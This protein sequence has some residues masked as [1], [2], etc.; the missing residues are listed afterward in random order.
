MDE[1]RLKNYR[2]FKSEQRARI[3]PLTI[4]VG[5]NSAG[6]S[7]FLA[8]IRALWNLYHNHRVPNFNEEPFD[9]GTFDNIVFSGYEDKKFSKTFSAGFR[10]DDGTQI[11]DGHLPIWFD[12]EFGRRGTAPFPI[13]LDMKS[14]E[15]N[16]KLTLNSRDG[17]LAQV[18]IQTKRGSW[19]SE[20]LQDSIKLF[21]ENRLTNLRLIMPELTPISLL[22]S[23]EISTT[24][25]GDI[26]G[27]NG[28]DYTPVSK[29]SS[30]QISDNDWH[31]VVKLLDVIYMSTS[32][33][34]LRKR[35]S[36]ASSP[37]RSKPI[38]IYQS[39][40]F[41]WDPEGDFAPMYLANLC[42]TGGNEWIKIRDKLKE[43]GSQSGLFDE[44]SIHSYE[45]HGGGPFQVEVRRSGGQPKG[46]N[47][48]L[49]DMGY[50]V[51]QI[52][53]VATE[54]LR[55]D[56]TPLLLLQQPEVHLHPSAQAALGTL[57]LQTADREQIVIVESHSDHLLNRIRMDLRDRVGD[58]RPEDVS[59]LY[60]E[61]SDAGSMIYS[62]RIDEQGNMIDAPESYGRFFMDETKRSLN[63]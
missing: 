39:K 29:K 16:L 42:E 20:D 61:D 41:A 54:L 44:I 27:K 46:K 1:I 47:R 59:I 10:I 58:S 52:L 5:E 2:C 17:N 14:K 60:F 25:A 24:A 11:S 38:R 28:V 35:P 3:A 18:F 31:Q 62:L 13:K 57:L 19:K 6:K 21:E 12:V 26:W 53:P 49:I 37:V 40:L 56:P 9:F 22:Q 7:S 51:S 32:N 43:F 30:T 33:Y 45:K 8:M 23:R 50:G 34:Y 15:K 55:E 4:L 63:L 36:Y 48:N